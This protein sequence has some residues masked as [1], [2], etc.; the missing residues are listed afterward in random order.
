MKFYQLKSMEG[1][2]KRDLTLC[3]D[4]RGHLVEILDKDLPQGAAK[5]EYSLATQSKFSVIRGMHSQAD[6]WQIVTILFGRVH[7]VLLDLRKASKTFG[8]VY[9]II[10]D[11]EKPCQLL[12]PP[13]VLH[14]FECLSQIAILN[15]HSN[16]Y[17]DPS[18]EVRANV[19]SDP[20]KSIWMLQSHIISEKDSTVAKLE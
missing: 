15:Y 14:G 9:S 20:I 5:F 1:V 16:V 10:M 19:Y 18:K 6:Q 8:E 4:N 7:D 17:F 11:S 13:G 2:Y 3:K 12:I